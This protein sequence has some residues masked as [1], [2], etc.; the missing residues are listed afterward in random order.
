MDYLNGILYYL[1]SFPPYKRRG[2]YHNLIYITL[3]EVPKVK[4]IK[5]APLN[6]ASKDPEVIRYRDL[7]INLAVQYFNN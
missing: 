3:R 2:T 6:I 4:F 7:L 1:L 5:K